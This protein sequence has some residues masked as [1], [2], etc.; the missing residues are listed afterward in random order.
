MAKKKRRKP[1]VQGVEAKLKTKIQGLKTEISGLEDLVKGYR[2][3]ADKILSEAPQ[4][5]NLTSE[6]RREVLES[7]VAQCL[8]AEGSTDFAQKFDLNATI[9]QVLMKSKGSEWHWFVIDHNRGPWPDPP[10]HAEAS[11]MSYME[12]LKAMY[13]VTKT[14]KNPY[15]RQQAVN[16]WRWLQEARVFHFDPETYISVHHEVDVW[17]TESLAGLDWQHPK[18]GKKP[19]AEETKKL[20][21]AVRHESMVAP[22]PD[23]FP[24]SCVFLGY[25]KGVQVSKDIIYPNIPDALQDRIVAAML[26]GHLMN[27]DGFALRFY[28]VEVLGDSGPTLSFL[29]ESVRTAPNG[30]LRS[31]FNLEPWIL[32]HL[33]QTINEHRTFV[34]ETQMPTGMR[35]RY[36]DERK[37][38]GLKQGQWAYTPPP[39]YMLKLQTKVIQERV[40]KGLPKPRGPM[41]YRTDVRA[42][43]RCRIHR[44][45]LP[46]DPDVR[47]KLIKRG[48]KIFTTNELDKDTLYRLQERGLAFKRADEW[49]A[50]LTSWV[51]SHFT[52]NDPKLPYVPACRLP[53]NIK[54]RQRPISSSW[55]HDPASV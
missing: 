49:L 40:R 36:K 8:Q 43:E 50:V 16:V 45:K 51:E 31:D 24:F 25:G 22:Y 4:S 12:V 46:L 14:E 29:I 42:H 33:I 54:G 17:T 23:R 19:P 18:T 7:I 34:L 6:E 52:C 13:V 41:A 47:D 38:M 39:Y 53:G 44:G 20:M 10:T 21:E 1:T 35:H 15:S 2:E 11:V 3:E 30:W 5:Q 27:S 28:A 55:V 9:H 26:L 32:P 37:Q 48:Y